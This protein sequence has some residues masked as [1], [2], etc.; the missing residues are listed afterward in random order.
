M[1]HGITY[2]TNDISSRIFLEVST[3]E[4]AVPFVKVLQPIVNLACIS[5]SNCIK[6]HPPQFE[7]L[8]VCFLSSSPNFM[9][10]WA[11]SQ[12]HSAGWAFFGWGMVNVRYSRHFLLLGRTF[13]FCFFFFIFLSFSIFIFLSFRLSISQVIWG[14]LRFINHVIRM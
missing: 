8:L 2:F 1:K 5:I 7:R 14:L 4:I 3:T 10:C 9:P 13:L 6:G 12:T 11:R